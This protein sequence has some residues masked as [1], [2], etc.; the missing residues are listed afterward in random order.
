MRGSWETARSLSHSGGRGSP[1]Q[2]RKRITD[3]AVMISRLHAQLAALPWR[4]VPVAYDKRET[5]ARP[6]RAA[7]PQGN[8]GGQGPGLPPCRPGHPD[9]PPPQSQ[10]KAVTRNLLR[11]HLARCHPRPAPPSSRASSV[12]TEGSRTGCTGSATWTSMRTARRS[13]PPAVPGLW[14]AYLV[15][16]ILRLAGATSIAAA[17]RYHA[18]RPS[19]PLRTIMKC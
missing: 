12:A 1:Y 14:P 4:D 7:H 8:R 15:I 3:L 18:R 17:L 2:E 9:H 11:G 16:T 6:R 13:A 19:R 10:G 5:R